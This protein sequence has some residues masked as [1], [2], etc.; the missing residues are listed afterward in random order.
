MKAA[1][2]IAGVQRSVATSHANMP[3]TSATSATSAQRPE[4]MIARGPP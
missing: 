2:I 4:L 3:S 1:S